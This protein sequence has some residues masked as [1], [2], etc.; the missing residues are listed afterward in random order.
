MSD[1]VLTPSEGNI[2]IRISDGGF[3]DMIFNAT[4]NSY[5]AVRLSRSKLFP[6]GFYKADGS[7]KYLNFQAIDTDVRSGFVSAEISQG[8]LKIN[9]KEISLPDLKFENGNVGVQISPENAEV[10]S[11]SMNNQV[12]NFIPEGNRWP[13]L[14]RHFLI[15]TVVA[16]LL[17]IIPQFGPKRAAVLLLGFGTL[18][19][20]WDIMMGFD[21]RQKPD[22][23]TEKF[24]KLDS[25]WKPEGE[26][27]IQEK[28]K[29][30]KVDDSD[31]AL[32]LCRPDGCSRAQVHVP[33]PPKKGLRILI[34]GGS[35][36]KYALI[37]KYEESMHFRFDRYLRESIPSVETINISTPGHFI[38]RV[39]AF[40]PKL[41]NVGMD[42]IIL[43]SKVSENDHPAIAGFLM[44]CRKQNVKVVMLRTPQNI[45]NYGEVAV[46]VVI[47]AL[48]SGLNAKLTEVPENYLW[49]P[50]RNISFIRDIQKKYN[51][52]FLDPNQI[53]LDENVMR[54][55]QLFWD[56]T[57][58]TIHGQEIFAKWLAGELTTL[59][60][61][62]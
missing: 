62:N 25:W 27:T 15:L 48:K 57:H 55:G 23:I 39:K 40:G 42:I 8:V 16:F 49:L 1:E 56:K 46:P 51:F 37:R 18:I 7:E 60:K 36:S 61:T 28:M 58:M 2:K 53:F 34:F 14:A 45:L 6:S 47:P 30:L 13:L 50:L 31:T 44:E 5:H 19:L 33:L 54:S 26:K 24:R 41:S 29:A 10:L 59:L 12:L 11:F 22:E 20:L 21:N 35:Q 43:E 3:V 52:M 32:F 38:D 17:G 9:G 4:K